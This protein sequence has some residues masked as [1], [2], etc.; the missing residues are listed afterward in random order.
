MTTQCPRFVL[1]L[2]ILIA[3]ISQSQAQKTPPDGEEQKISVIP[4]TQITPHHLQESVK[5]PKTL[6]G[7]PGQGGQAKLETLFVGDLNGDTVDDLII[8]ASGADPY[9]RTNAG[10]VY[11]LYGGDEFHDRRTPIFQDG[12]N[13][14]TKPVREGLFDLRDP[15]SYD[16]R[17]VGTTGSELGASLGIGDLDGDHLPDLIIGAP[18]R[19]YTKCEDCGA[20]IV[21]FGKNRPQEGTLDLVEANVFQIVGRLPGSR[22]GDALLFKDINFDGMD[23]LMVTGYDNTTAEVILY[24]VMGYAYPDKGM[25]I[26]GNNEKFHF[27]IRIPAAKKLIKPTVSLA[28]GDHNRDTL[29]DIALAIS[30]GSKSSKMDAGTVFIFYNARQFPG[31]EYTRKNWPSGTIAIEGNQTGSNLGDTILF[32]DI[33]GD[34]VDDLIMTSPNR[35]LNGPVSEG[36]V[37]I[38]WGTSIMPEGFYKF[39]DLELLN[40]IGLMG[41]NFGQGITLEDINGDGY[42]DLLVSTPNASTEYGQESGILELIIGG[43]Q[44][45]GWDRLDP[46]TLSY[47]IRITGESELSHLGKTLVTGDFDNNGETDLVVYSASPELDPGQNGILAVVPNMLNPW[48]SRDVSINELPSGISFLGP[49]RGGGL[50]SKSLLTDDLNGDG[51]P[52]FILLSPV[53]GDR[54]TPVLCVLPQTMLGQSD[55]SADLDKCLFYAHLPKRVSALA[56]ADLVGDSRPD[57][58]LGLPEMGYDKNNIPGAVMIIPG[59]VIT[60]RNTPRLDLFNNEHYQKVTLLWGETHGSR[61]GTAIATAHITGNKK[62]DLLVSAPLG[63]PDG[64]GQVDLLTGPLPQA[65]TRR[66]IQGSTSNYRWLG[67]SKNSRLGLEVGIFKDRQDEVTHLWFTALS[68]KADKRGAV[69]II[70]TST[71][72]EGTHDLSDINQF[73]TRLDA[74]AETTRLIPAS[75]HCDI[76]QDTFNDFMLVAPRDSTED[77]R[78]AGTLYILPGPTFPAGIHTVNESPEVFTIQGPEKGGTLVSPFGGQ[79]GNTPYIFVTC[80]NC[81]SKF[82]EHDGALYGIPLGALTPATDLASLETV[83]RIDL[84]DH[85]SKRRFLPELWSLTDDQHPDLVMIYDDSEEQMRTGKLMVIDGEWLKELAKNK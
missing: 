80:N 22:L 75:T 63:G 23:D 41:G 58:I 7:P 30:Q 14:I 65:G 68:T 83:F 45:Y 26:V 34:R 50:S 42:K 6:F 69:Y 40:I 43:P 12:I 39:D 59:E 27:N 4:D 57:I 76:N 74:P 72:Q 13:S 38:L 29:P 33:N 49:E 81:N 1:S 5:N 52:D 11:V 16:L 67:D 44:L 60:D 66:V 3:F 25:I 54:G 8:G 82:P 46:D 36:M 79:L 28:I 51:E 19:T 73:T 55:Q 35:L 31:N 2:L 64:S 15:S 24:G 56:S 18:G 85:H 62:S 61:T 37:S 84:P 53:G 48:P 9:S 78:H 47:N 77:R 71:A 70:E 10:A 17:I 20:A 21:I 32:A